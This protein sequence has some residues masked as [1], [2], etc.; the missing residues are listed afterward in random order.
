MDLPKAI[1]FVTPP[2]T[3]AEVAELVDLPA[4]RRATAAAGR[5]ACHWVGLN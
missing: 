4:F 5:P 2:G 1:I 3:L